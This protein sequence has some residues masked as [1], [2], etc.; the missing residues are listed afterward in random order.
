V[1]EQGI[2]RIRTNQALRELYI[3]LDRV[4]NVKRKR[5]ELIGHVVRMDQGM[6]YKKI[7]ESK[8]KGSRRRGRPRLRWLEDMEKDQ[9]EKKVKR[10][11]QKAVDKDNGRPQLRRKRQSEGRRAK[12]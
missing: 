8:P 1:V 6:T 12:E 9:W 10:R 7:F 3:N 11:R 2:C 4:A 5:L